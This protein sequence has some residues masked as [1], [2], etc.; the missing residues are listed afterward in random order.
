MIKT[1]LNQERIERHYREGG[2]LGLTYLDLWEK[3]LKAFPDKTF[4]IDSER[5]VTFREFDLEV[6]RLAL[7]LIEL[8]VKKE[9]LVSVQLP[10]NIEFFV[11]M[12][13]IMRIGAIVVPLPIRIGREDLKRLSGL[14]NPVASIIPREFSR[15]VSIYLPFGRL[16]ISSPEP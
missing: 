2:W 12:M 7:R 9:G 3:A 16:G 5:A 8:G 10:S 14:C 11:A 6:K 1:N 4:I 13:A 15:V